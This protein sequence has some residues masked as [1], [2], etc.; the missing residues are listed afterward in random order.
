MSCYGK[1]GIM[2]IQKKME[3]PDCDNG[4][5]LLCGR[6]ARAPRPAV[7]DITSMSG[8]FQNKVS[9]TRLVV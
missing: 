7:I 5:Y 2:N 9:K 8:R 6:D 1:H 3:N 4:C